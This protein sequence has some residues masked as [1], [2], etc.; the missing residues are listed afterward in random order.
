MS[1]QI[2]FRLIPFLISCL[3]LL[4]CLTG[5]TA[6]QAE[7]QPVNLTT[8]NKQYDIEIIL[9]ENA[10]DKYIHSEIWPQRLYEAP[11]ESDTTEQNSSSSEPD[12]PLTTPLAE[13]QPEN[14]AVEQPLFSQLEGSI[15]ASEADRIQ[16]SSQYNMLFYSAWRQD[17]LDKTEA[18]EI[19]LNELK[20]QARVRSANTL[21]GTIKVVL[22]RYLHFYTDM[23]YHRANEQ[24]VVET[25]RS[26]H[27]V[28]AGKDQPG[29]THTAEVP[30]DVS[31][32]RQNQLADETD[33]QAT[34]LLAPAEPVLKIN[35][36]PVKT[37]RRMRSK[38]LHYIDHPLVG[39][40]VQINPVEPEPV[41]SAPAKPGKE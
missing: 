15:L 12:A 19:D 16:R 13:T 23:E 22:A 29:E 41:E 33:N 31:A 28:Q 11:A 10:H 30:I 3:T 24:P 18:F 2:L 38:E 7:P 26:D 21:T 25:V 35:Y 36:Y 14:Q 40:L 17:G 4:G 37:H 6:L 39:I 20:N 5:S 8:D 1:R 27:F 34:R 9:F 32:Q